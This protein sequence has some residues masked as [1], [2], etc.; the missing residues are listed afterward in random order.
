MGP[1]PASGGK[2][3]QIPVSVCL[4]RRGPAGL[5]AKSRCW[6][7]LHFSSARE[8]PDQ[9]LDKQ[10]GAFVPLN[11]PRDSSGEE[12][13]RVFKLFLSVQPRDGILTVLQPQLRPSSGWGD[14]LPEW[15]TD[16]VCSQRKQILW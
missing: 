6:K 16:I 5:G 11:F 14:D 1:G 8:A 9:G 12:N 2:E 3:I 15:G 13:H 4:T 7:G 10:P